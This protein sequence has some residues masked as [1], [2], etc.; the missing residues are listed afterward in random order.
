M[1]HMD[2]IARHN[3]LRSAP[4]A[5]VIEL[6]KPTTQ[7]QL[8]G[9]ESRNSGMPFYTVFCM[10]L[11]LQDPT[12]AGQ[13][14]GWKV[15]LLVWASRN[16]F[17]T[18]KEPWD[19]ISI[20]TDQDSFILGLKLGRL[21]CNTPTIHVWPVHVQ[22]RINCLRSWASANERENTPTRVGRTTARDE[23]NIRT[24]N[25]KKNIHAKRMQQILGL[26][27]CRIQMEGTLLEVFCGVAYLIV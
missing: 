13:W 8:C 22:T 6:Q 19:I 4:G 10:L 27:F 15:R 12:T 20:P 26:H 3:A 21:P 18:Q 2:N 7:P 14:Q 24:K 25:A 17:Y 9:P 1:P 23:G 16:V 5:S 11:F